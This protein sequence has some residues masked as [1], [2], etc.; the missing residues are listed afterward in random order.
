MILLADG[1]AGKLSDYLREFSLGSLG[2][3]ADGIVG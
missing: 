2:K 1:V 3:R